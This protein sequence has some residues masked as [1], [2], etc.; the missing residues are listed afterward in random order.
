MG[1]G[2]KADAAAYLV[3]GDEI[4]ALRLSLLSWL[5]LLMNGDAWLMVEIIRWFAWGGKITQML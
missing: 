3:G 1:Q 2:L 5:E 4:G